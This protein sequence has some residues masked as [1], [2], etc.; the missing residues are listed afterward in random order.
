M[1][2]NN[3]KTFPVGRDSRTGQFIPIKEAQRRPKTTT[4][5]IERIPKA[6]KG[7]T[8]KELRSVI[9]KLSRRK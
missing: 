6:G 1:S 2:K 5:T 7:D 9:N 4:I 8:S 3:S